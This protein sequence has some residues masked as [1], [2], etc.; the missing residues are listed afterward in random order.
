MSYSGLRRPHKGGPHRGILLST[1][2]DEKALIFS[3][4][5][6]R[7]ERITIRVQGR[8]KAKANG[9]YTGEKKKQKERH[10][11]LPPTTSE[12]KKGKDAV[13]TTV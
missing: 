3:P 1:R 9:D 13:A 2:K 6:R 8:G 11:G 4:P 10:N 7:E 12:K 5:S